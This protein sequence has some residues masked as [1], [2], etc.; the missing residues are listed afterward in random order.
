LT[1]TQRRN[2]ITEKKNKKNNVQTNQKDL[3]QHQ[4]IQLSHAVATRIIGLLRN[5]VT[6]LVKLSA[7]SL[8]A[9]QRR[10]V[11]LTLAQTI[12]RQIRIQRQRKV[13]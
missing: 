8:I 7:R 13:I 2:E 6:L 12:L 5:T 10:R 1:A 11:T 9:I 3:E 4:Q